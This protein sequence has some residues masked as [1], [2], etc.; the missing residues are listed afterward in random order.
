M[1]FYIPKILKD[2]GF[3]KTNSVKNKRK[4]IENP[5]KPKSFE[6]ERVV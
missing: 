4:K 3:E 2:L 5:L 1:D 6:R